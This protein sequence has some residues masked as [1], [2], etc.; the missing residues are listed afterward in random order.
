MRASRWKPV[1]RLVQETRFSYGTKMS[2]VKGLGSLLLP[3]GARAQ[4]Q[5]F[6]RKDLEVNYEPK[7][8][9][10]EMCVRE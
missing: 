10:S 4:G 8:C 9:E 6:V 3:S 5:S 1:L 2:L 7:K